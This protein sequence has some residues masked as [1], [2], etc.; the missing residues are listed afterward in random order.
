MGNDFRMSR[1]NARRA[2]YFATRIG[3]LFLDPI[4][5]SSLLRHEK[6]AAEQTSEHVHRPP[7]TPRI[8]E[9][10][11]VDLSA[12]SNDETIMNEIIER[13]NPSNEFEQYRELDGLLDYSTSAEES[14]DYINTKWKKKKKEKKDKT[15]LNSNS[16]TPAPTEAF[17]PVDDLTIPPELDACLLQVLPRRETTRRKK[18]KKNESTALT[19]QYMNEIQQDQSIG[20]DYIASDDVHSYVTDYSEIEYDDSH[21]SH[22]DDDWFDTYDD[23]EDHEEGSDDDDGDDDGDE[24]FGHAMYTYDNHIHNFLYHDDDEL[25]DSRNLQ[26]VA[27]EWDRIAVSRNMVSF[28]LDYFGVFRTDSFFAWHLDQ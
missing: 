23:D 6:G 27:D 20:F 14:S 9:E 19:Q 28:E 7:P 8:S 12:H 11:S 18:K 5:G 4:R 15:K 22:F 10:P 3:F 25:S 13:L 26:L 1:N 21:N 17:Q 16:A 2:I 24:Y